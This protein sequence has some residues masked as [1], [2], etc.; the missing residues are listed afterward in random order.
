M[1]STSN[2]YLT[3]FIAGATGGAGVVEEKDQINLVGQTIQIDKLNCFIK[4]RVPCGGEELYALESDKPMSGYDGLCPKC[5]RTHVAFTRSSQGFY[6]SVKSIHDKIHKETL[7]NERLKGRKEVKELRTVKE[8][9]PP[10]D[11]PITGKNKGIEGDSNSCYMDATIYCMFA[12][13]DVFD[14]LLHME[15]KTEALIKL[16]K[17]LRENIVNVLRSKYGFVDRKIFFKVYL[18]LKK[19]FYVNR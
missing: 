13:N 1:I 14:S 9:L 4:A 2:S 15:P 3:N 19:E 8:N 11:Q 12:Y 5:R 17:T 18:F 16:Q 7:S 10:L 6:A